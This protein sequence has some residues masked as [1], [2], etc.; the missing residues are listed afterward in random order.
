LPTKAKLPPKPAGLPA[1]P[2]FNAFG[3]EEG[4]V[5]KEMY[6]P[7]EG[8]TKDL[9]KQEAS[10][11]EAEEDEDED[12]A[13]A[14]P[15]GAS[16]GAADEEDDPLDAFMSTVT[17]EV[18]KV[19]EA[20]KAKGG[21]INVRRLAEQL[22]DESEGEGAEAEGDEL[23]KAGLR[24]EDI[25]AC[26][27]LSVRLLTGTK[28]TSVFGR[29]AAKKIKRRDLAPVNHSQINYEPFTKAFYHAP[30][31]VEKMTPEEVDL[32]RVELDD[33]KIRGVD[34]PKPVVKWSHCG[35]TAKRYVPF[36]CLI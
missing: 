16:N 17:N 28:L 35:L 29:L 25:L 32:L 14:P 15:A 3:K 26:V 1:K 9:G 31:E 12:V 23:D 11:A 27:H 13:M 7:E 24:P 30:P 21:G 36:F 19:D 33:I 8:G 4:G 34:C 18:K 20:D 2:S 6:R 22:Q 5:K 10:K